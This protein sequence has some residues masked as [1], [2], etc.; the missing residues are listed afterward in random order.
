[1][2]FRNFEENFVFS[3]KSLEEIFEEQ[4]PLRPGHRRIKR[5]SKQEMYEAVVKKD[6]YN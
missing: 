5:L 2:A 6:V 3:L 1:M 4:F